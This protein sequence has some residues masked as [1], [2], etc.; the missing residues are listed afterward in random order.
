MALIDLNRPPGEY[1]GAARPRLHQRTTWRW[2]SATI[3][4]LLHLFKEAIRR[5]WV[6]FGPQPG[7]PTPRS[8]T[9]WPNPHASSSCRKKISSGPDIGEAET[10]SVEGPPAE[11]STEAI[12]DSDQI[13][14]TGGYFQRQHMPHPLCEHVRY[15][16]DPGIAG[17]VASVRND[18]SGDKT[19]AAASDAPQIPFCRVSLDPSPA[20]GSQPVRGRGMGRA[21]LWTGSSTG[22]MARR[23]WTGSYN[24][25]L[26][27]PRSREN[28]VIMSEPLDIGSAYLI[29]SGPGHRWPCA[30]APDGNSEWTA[31]SGA[32][33]APDAAAGTTAPP[34]RRPPSGRA[35]PEKTLM[36]SGGAVWQGCAGTA[37]LLGDL[38][39]QT[40]GRGELVRMGEL[41]QGPPR[42]RQLGAGPRGL[43]PGRVADGPHGDGQR[44]PRNAGRN[45]AIRSSPRGRTA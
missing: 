25:S 39:H 40:A 38:A 36:P 6:C 44:G 31:P 37:L 18:R 24:C 32:I 35:K 20:P 3:G 9:R 7:S 17:V 11:A 23:S 13:G 29:T 42:E 28:A 16:G 41:V 26:L 45:R 2:C 30:G 19:Q 4:R 34:G 27:A 21:G 10:A 5:G 1:P 33:A 8:S 15:G 22:R 43:R 14:E 12:E